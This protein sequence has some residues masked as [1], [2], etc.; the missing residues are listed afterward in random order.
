M[1]PS[2]EQDAKSSGRDKKNTVHYSSVK[3]SIFSF[4]KNIKT[5][6]LT[7]VELC[8]HCILNTSIY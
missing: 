4:A 3:L 1:Y 8:N 5:K 2:P 7:G 6:F